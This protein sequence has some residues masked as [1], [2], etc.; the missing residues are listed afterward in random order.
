MLRNT[1]I[2]GFSVKKSAAQSGE[3]KGENLTKEKK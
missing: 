2:A 1:E 3:E